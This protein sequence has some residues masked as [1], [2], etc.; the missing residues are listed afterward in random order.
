M[1]KFLLLTLL[2]IPHFLIA[3]ATHELK[4]DL[5]GLYWQNK[6]YQVAYEFIPSNGKFGLGGGLIYD[7]AK[8]SLDTNSIF[9]APRAMNY[10]AAYIG[11]MISGRYY[12]SSKRLGKGLYVGPHL[13]I[14]RWV[15][16]NS[17]YNRLFTE[18]YGAKPRRLEKPWNSVAAGL[19]VGFKWLLWKRL[20]LE[21]EITAGIDLVDAFREMFPSIYPEGMLFIRLGYRL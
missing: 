3:Q 4:T 15:V 14:E 11:L 17:E 19:Q 9:E 8:V 16:H 13:F 5:L 1:K 7:P 10:P 18:Q 6:Q 20:V 21:P 2:S 12:F